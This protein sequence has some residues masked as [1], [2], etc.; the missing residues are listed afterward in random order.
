MSITAHRLR[1]VA[2][3]APVSATSAP[4]TSWEDVPLFLSVEEA[5]ALLRVN[6]KTVYG[7][8]GQGLKGRIPGCR[9]VRIRKDHLLSFL[10]SR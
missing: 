9:K 4:R 7:W 6:R 5:A 8:L 2:K 1:A 3:T 10:D